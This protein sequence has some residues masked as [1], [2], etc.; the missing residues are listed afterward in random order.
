MSLLFFS[1]IYI[2]K[3]LLDCKY[4]YVPLLI[5]KAMGM[6]HLKI[7]GTGSY[8]PGEKWAERAGS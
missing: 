8:F 4:V 7:V 1:Y 5:E 3:L 2:I 6:P